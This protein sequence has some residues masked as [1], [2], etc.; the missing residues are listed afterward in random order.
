[1]CESEKVSTTSVQ[2]PWPITRFAVN[3][4]IG[5]IHLTSDNQ[6][7]L[8]DNQNYWLSVTFEWY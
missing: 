7:T 6:T 3:G 8:T 1:M 2:F 4:A 5:S